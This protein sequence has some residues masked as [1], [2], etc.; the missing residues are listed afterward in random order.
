MASGAAQQFKMPCFVILKVPPI[1]FFAQ[2]FKS[3]ISLSYSS[4]SVSVLFRMCVLL[5]CRLKLRFRFPRLTEYKQA[6]NTPEFNGNKFKLINKSV[7]LFTACLV[8]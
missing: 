3:K 1:G 6:E 2:L 7:F 4:S 8:L 5:R